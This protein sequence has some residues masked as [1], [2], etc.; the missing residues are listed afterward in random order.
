MAAT[1]MCGPPVGAGGRLFSTPTQRYFLRRGRNKEVVDEALGESFGGVLVSDFYAAYHHYA[2]PKHRCWAHL[3]R[4][5][6]GLRV[7]YPQDHRLAQWADAVHQ[8]YRPGRGLYPSRRE[9][10]PRRPTGPGKTPAGPL[11]SLPG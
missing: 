3:L 8:L 6:N 1:A 7:L 9:A 11:P 10:T 2:G 5:I 4:D